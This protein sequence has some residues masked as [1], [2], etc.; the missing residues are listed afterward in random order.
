MRLG[1]PGPPRC[2]RDAVLGSR[3]LRILM[4]YLLSGEGPVPRFPMIRRA[5][6]RRLLA[7]TVAG[8]TGVTYGSIPHPCGASFRS[9]ASTVGCWAVSAVP[10]AVAGPAI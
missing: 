5:G 6:A 3:Y 4:L 7:E 2:G 8:L 9:M 10:S 1:A